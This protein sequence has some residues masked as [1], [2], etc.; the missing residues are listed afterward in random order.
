MHPALLVL[1]VTGVGLSIA[2]TVVSWF[3]LSSERDFRS[4]Y[5]HAGLLALAAAILATVV[6]GRATAASSTALC[7]SA[8]FFL[9]SFH[10][11]LTGRCI[12]PRQ[13]V[14]PLTIYFAFDILCDLAGLRL[15]VGVLMINSIMASC[16]A[17]LLVMI[18]RQWRRCHGNGLLVIAF[19]VAIPGSVYM[20]R[21]LVMLDGS[22]SPLLFSYSPV[23]NAAVISIFI[24]FVLKITGYLIFALEKTHRRHLDDARTIAAAQERGR[25]AQQHADTMR[26][27]V[28]QRDHMILA[29]SRFSAAN[30][31][32]VFNSAIVHEISQPLQALRTRVEVMAARDAANGAAAADDL[33][34]VRRLVD[35][36]ANTLDNLRRLLGNQ[37]PERENVD[38][39]ELLG[40]VLPILRSEMDRR[41]I[42]LDLA[43]G[44]LAPGRIVQCNRILFERLLL[45]LFSN[46]I[47]AL[48][49][50]PAGAERRISLR[51]ADRD[52]AGALG[53]TVAVEDNGP[54]FPAPLLE[55]PNSLFHTTKAQGLGLGLSLVRIIAESWRGSLRLS[56]GGAAGDTGARAELD[57]PLARREPAGA[58]F[59]A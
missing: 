19:G 34:A 31:L 16:Y 58:G 13:L 53:V 23:T 55:K 9:A 30:S 43:E 35:K 48:D 42:R 11:E 54:G 1:A 38:L 33:A 52:E 10:G 24:G 37:Q 40:E 41:A 27:L 57:L 36:L 25:L 6:F 8:A 5:W 3:T 21:A 59:L 47:E 32:A 50:L 49:S 28:L 44:A 51:V 7:A 12:S 4:S 39:G 29:S 17:V 15:T 46:A 45:N 20:V 26:D 18:L 22:A 14:L 2:L 56:N